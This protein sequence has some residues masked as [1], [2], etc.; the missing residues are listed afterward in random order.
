MVAVNSQSE[1][2]A[3]DLV[4]ESALCMPCVWLV[5]EQTEWGLGAGGLPHLL[6]Q[7]DRE[8]SELRPTLAVCVKILP[9]SITVTAAHVY[10]RSY[11]SV[12]L[13]NLLNYRIYLERHNR[14]RD[15]T[16]ASSL[17]NSDWLPLCISMPG[18]SGV[19]LR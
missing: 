10:K 12:Q 2:C 8:P 17:V 4:R 16:V 15:R 6:S 5:W 9:S 11:L 1:C 3:V 13:S 7:A 18:I 14:Y 19:L